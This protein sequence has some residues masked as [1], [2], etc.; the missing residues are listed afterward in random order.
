ME[1][2]EV[3]YQPFRMEVADVVFL[4]Q[5]AQPGH[6]EAK[7][8]KDHAD[9]DRAPPR[10]SY[11]RDCVQIVAVHHIV[12]KAPLDGLAEIVVKQQVLLFQL[13]ER[14]LRLEAICIESILL[15]VSLLT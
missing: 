12:T 1:F 15:Y 11:V 9:V 14:L 2:M 6:Q 7:Y 4:A 5:S 13:F 3:L 10:L 8:E